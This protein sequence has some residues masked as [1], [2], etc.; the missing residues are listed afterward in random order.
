M[1]HHPASAAAVDI[2]TNTVKMTA[3]RVAPGGSFEITTDSGVQTRLGEGS[4]SAGLLSDEAIE[5]T[6]AAAAE[7]VRRARELGAEMVRIVTTSAAREAANSA[8]FINAVCAATGVQPVVLSGEDEARL[9]FLSVAMDPELGSFE[10][11]QLVVDVGGGSTELILGQGN[12][13]LAAA[14]AKIGAV[15]LTERLL[16]A[17]NPSDSEVARA[18]A[19]TEEILRSVFDFGAADRVVGIG[20]SAVNLAR[21]YCEVPV[22]ATTRVHGV[23]IPVDRL[24]GLVQHLSALDLQQKK[25]LAGLEP[26]RADIILAGAIILERA[27]K[28]SRADGLTISTR[29]LRH[30]VLYEMLAEMR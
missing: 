14:S 4:D 18:A 22:E 10:G 24:S 27:V 21:I 16:R 12:R 17:D 7:F 13:I 1:K 3:G 11:R 26:G 20:G 15:R 8:D 2:G 25:A 9:S 23:V 30:G 6:A 29:G 19:E 28:L 5:R